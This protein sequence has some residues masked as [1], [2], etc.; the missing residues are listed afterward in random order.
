MSEIDSTEIHLPDDVRAELE[1]ERFGS[2]Q[3]YARATY[4]LGC[5][6]PLCRLA[7]KHRGRTRNEKKAKSEGREYIPLLDARKEQRDA[8]L[9]PIVAWHLMQR[10]GRGLSVPAATV[11]P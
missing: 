10:G 3:H 9:A 6:G 8:E 1:D 11:A 5:R 7:E 4:A 2:R